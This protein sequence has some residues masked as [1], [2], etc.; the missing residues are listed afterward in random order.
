MTP[1][2]GQLIS[3]TNIC[4]E[5]KEHKVGFGDH[6]L[7]PKELKDMGYLFPEQCKQIFEAT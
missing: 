1:E 7:D 3:P 4:W 6:L 5:Q 2:K